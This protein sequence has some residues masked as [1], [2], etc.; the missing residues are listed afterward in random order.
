MSTAETPQTHAEAAL[1]L[2]ETLRSLQSGIPGFVIPPA[3]L[4]R[5]VRPRGHRLLPDRFFESLAVALDSSPQ[6]A[7]SVKLTSTEI[8]DM[9]RYGEA[10]LSVAAE[11]ERF[12][13]GI[14]FGVASLRANVGR[15]ASSAYLVAQ[16]MNLIVDVDLPVPEVESMKRAIKER[17]R[18]GKGNGSTAPVATPPAAANSSS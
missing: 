8:R 17:R 16:G 4:D 13:R 6:F 5:Q 11:L 15:R 9:L 2:V 12:A 7:A 10:Y 1:R 14:K 3:P 18:K